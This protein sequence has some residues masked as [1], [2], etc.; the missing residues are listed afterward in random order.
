MHPSFKADVYDTTR[1]GLF[2]GRNTM[3]RL[4]VSHLRT[5]RAMNPSQ[6][7]IWVDIGGGTGALVRFL[8]SRTGTNHRQVTTSSSWTST[9]PSLSSTPSTSS[10]S[11]NRSWTSL[12]NASLARGGV[13]L[14]SCTR[15]RRSFPFPSG[16]RPIP[17][18]ASTLSPS[19][20]RSPWSV[21]LSPRSKCQHLC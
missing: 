2:R 18:A 5:L 21:L 13:T 11:V 7:H 19:A 16:P 17:K 1:S 20:I 4:S 14:R 15:M 9:F 3:L 6:R 10:I 8:F 12:G